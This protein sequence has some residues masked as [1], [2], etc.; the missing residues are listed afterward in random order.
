M[1]CGNC[2]QKGNDTSYAA[3]SIPRLKPSI[4]HT[5]PWLKPPSKMRWLGTPR[6]RSLWINWSTVDGKILNI[7]VCFSNP[8]YHV[9]N[10]TDS[11]MPSSSIFSKCA[12]FSK[13]LMLNH[14]FTRAPSPKDVIDFNGLC[15]VCMS[16]SA[17]T[18]VA[19]MKKAET[20]AFG[21]IHLT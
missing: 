18:T 13:L 19:L 21:N 2:S 3:R 11:S 4:K 6:F 7:D 8:S 12:F 5:L 17:T 14:A 15:R 16:V 20:Y 10:P 1:R 9:P